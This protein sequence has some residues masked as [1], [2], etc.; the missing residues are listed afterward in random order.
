MNNTCLLCVDTYFLDSNLNCIEG[1][2][3]SKTYNFEYFSTG[4]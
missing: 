3:I 1:K 4:F 2:D